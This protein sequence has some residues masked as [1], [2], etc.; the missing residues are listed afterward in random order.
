[1]PMGIDNELFLAFGKGGIVP[2]IH[3]ETCQLGRPL[4]TK[5]KLQTNQHTQSINTV[6]LQWLEH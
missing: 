5:S 3:V 6:E 2:A 1:M 4:P